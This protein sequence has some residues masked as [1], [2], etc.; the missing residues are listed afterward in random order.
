MGGDAVM[1]SSSSAAAITGPLGAL[2]PSPTQSFYPLNYLISG[3]AARAAPGPEEGST[4]P[5]LH[6]LSRGASPAG[7]QLE[8]LELQLD[9]GARW[10]VRVSRVTFAPATASARREA[11]PG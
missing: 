8:R 6:V 9:T 11:G 1:E 7:Q 2:C 4:L 10:V 5:T 3:G